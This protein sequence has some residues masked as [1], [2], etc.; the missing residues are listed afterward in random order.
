MRAVRLCLLVLR[1]GVAI[2]IA[3]R[4]ARRKD[5][6]GALAQTLTGGGDKDAPAQAMTATMAMAIEKTMTF[7]CV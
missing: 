1:L 4:R 5:W 7:F 3:F 6:L 2:C